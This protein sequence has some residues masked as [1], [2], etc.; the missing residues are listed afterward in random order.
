M[1]NPER[2][3]LFTDGEGPLIFKDIA[4]DISKKLIIEN[5]DTSLPG[6]RFFDTISMFNLFI[7]ETGKRPTEPGDTL[8]FL[9][10]HLLAHEVTDTDLDV[11]SQDTQLAHGVE[12]YLGNLR[13]DGWNIRVISSAYNSLWDTVG[14]KLGFRSEEIAS[15]DLNLG[16]LK[17]E[18]WTEEMASVVIEAEQFLLSKKRAIEFAQQSFRKG[19]T[20]KEIFEQQ[21]MT[22]I[23]Q[24]LDDLYF[25][26]LPQ[27]GFN[28]LALLEVVGGKR[29]VKALSQFIFESNLEPDGI[30]Y[31]GD[32]I[33]D[34][35]VNFFLKKNG[36]LPIAVNGDY[37]ALRNARIAVATADMGDLKP[38]LDEFSAGAVE[39]AVSYAASIAISIGQQR[40]ISIDSQTVIHLLEPGQNLD[41]VVKVHGEF[42]NRI[43]G[44]STP[45]I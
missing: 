16:K 3:T 4:R 24:T 28:P 29:K 13:Q 45:L 41:E 19:A 15:T 23:A 34:D 39:G 8:A 7:H 22:Q 36:G 35:A 21:E 14:P 43:R 42:R 18:H 26:Q 6:Q 31:V 38:I 20:I 33:T 11:E 44:A 32:S 12:R 17:R 1:L 9:V 2:N 27:L 5:Q 30:P 40:D 25:T 37:F 10:P